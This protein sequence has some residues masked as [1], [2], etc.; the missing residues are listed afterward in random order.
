MRRFILN[1][2][3]G[4]FQMTGLK[5]AIK[6]ICFFN[7]PQ[8][9]FEICNNKHWPKNTSL[10]K[11]RCFK[12]RFIQVVEQLFKISNKIILKNHFLTDWE[13]KPHKLILR[14]VLRCF[15]SYFEQVSIANAFSLTYH[16]NSQMKLL[17]MLAYLI[18]CLVEKCLTFH[19]FIK[20]ITK[21]PISIHN[22][23]IKIWP[24]CKK[25]L[26]RSHF[27]IASASTLLTGFWQVLFYK[28]KI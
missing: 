16:S 20:W 24:Q 27:L 5:G 4:F 1:W 6:N 3:W 2:E 9:A 7:V 11:D 28:S 21:K 22:N 18:W 10:K 8:T 15:T 19:Q 26:S 13:L 23:K 12:A 25:T 14:V 17:S